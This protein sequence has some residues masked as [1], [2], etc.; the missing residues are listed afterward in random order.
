MRKAV[1]AFLT[2]AAAAGLGTAGAVIAGRTSVR[3]HRARP[4]P[5]AGEDFG[6][7]PPE[8]LG[9]IASFDG[10]RLAV[11]AAGPE[12]A[13][14]I[15]FTHGITLDMTTWHY[16]WRTFSE[17]YR[18]VLFDHRSHGRSAPPATADYSLP[19]A[20]RDIRA[21]LD[22]AVP[23]GPVVLVGHSMGGMAILSFADQYPGEFGERVAGVVL[24]DTAA[25]D[26]VREFLGVVGSR[27]ERRLRPFTDRALWDRPERA[28]LIRSAMHRWGRDLAFLM[29]RTSNF[30]PEASAAQIDYVTRLSTGAPIEVWTQMLR[31]LM[32]MDLRD[33]LASI[34]VPSLVIV[35]DRDTLTPK[36]SARAIAD[37]LPDARAIVLTRAGH[38]AMMER[39]D[40]FNDLFGRYL[41]DVL[42][43]ARA[44]G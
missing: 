29:A 12:G 27:V 6:V 39:H 9:P 19:A 34:T 18:C 35:G 10:T 20:G 11:R 7:L 1:R 33:A 17:R 4:D 43:R 25:S 40:L 41:E 36:T 15:L 28:E 30:G 37:A 24:V 38:V 14:A 8:D 31:G 13:P 3:R 23:N 22:R 42:P 21:V 16:Q 26:I 5:E 44:A 32:E 2:G